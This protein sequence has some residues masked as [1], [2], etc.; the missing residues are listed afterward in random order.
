[1]SISCQEIKSPYV[2]FFTFFLP[3]DEQGKFNNLW[4]NKNDVFNS[5]LRIE[6]TWP[7][8]STH[9]QEFITSFSK[10]V[11]FDGHTKLGCGSQSTTGM[12]QEEFL[13]IKV[14]DKSL[15]N[16]WTWS[17]SVF[18]ISLYVI[19]AVW[20]NILAYSFLLN[21]KSLIESMYNILK[22]IKYMGSWLWTR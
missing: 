12:K 10:S 2:H 18:S 16:T 11:N 3:K 15:W 17:E 22:W 8:M 9:F 1:M 19:F 4:K 20:F 6:K 21:F 7:R 14:G 13:N 5:T